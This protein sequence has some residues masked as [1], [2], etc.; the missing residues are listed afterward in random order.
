MKENINHITE[1]YASNQSVPKFQKLKN[2]NHKG[3]LQV[4]GYNQQSN[5]R[6]GKGS[7]LASPDE[8]SLHN[9]GASHHVSS[10]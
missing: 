4:N 9:G 6:I 2:Y 8:R 7:N 1:V 3:N 5:S 10:V